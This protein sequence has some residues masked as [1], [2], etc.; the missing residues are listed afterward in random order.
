MSKETI[1]S[2]SLVGGTMSSGFTMNLKKPMSWRWGYVFLNFVVSALNEVPNKF[3]V[4][5]N[6][7]Y[8]IIRPKYHVTK[9]HG[10]TYKSSLVSSGR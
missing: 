2:A 5:Q 7:F 3:F 4:S 9:P 6:K 8:G 10:R 1:K